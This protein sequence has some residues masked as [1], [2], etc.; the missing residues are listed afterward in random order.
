M[1]ASEFK[2]ET[3]ERLASFRGRS[4]F[5]DRDIDQKISRISAQSDETCLRAAI[6]AARKGIL[7]AREEGNAEWVRAY[8]RKLQALSSIR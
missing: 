6:V 4:V 1:T 7:F 3:L 5:M 8:R 2:V